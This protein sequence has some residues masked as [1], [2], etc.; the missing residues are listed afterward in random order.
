MPKKNKSKRFFLFILGSLFNFG[1]IVYASNDTDIVKSEI[2]DISLIDLKDKIN[3]SLIDLK[4]SISDCYEFKSKFMS[5][6]V[7]KSNKTVS[8][9]FYAALISAGTTLCEDCLSINK[10]LSSLI[11]KYENK[12]SSEICT[13]Y[14]ELANNSSK[15]KISILSK[16]VILQEQKYEFSDLK[17]RISYNVEYLQK[18]L[19]FAQGKIDLPPIFE[20]YSIIDYDDALSIENEYGLSYL[21]MEN[22]ANN[23]FCMRQACLNYYYNVKNGLVEFEPS[24]WKS[25]MVEG[26]SL[27]PKSIQLNEK[28]LDAY[29]KKYNSIKSNENLQ[30]L[31]NDVYKMVQHFKSNLKLLNL[32]QNY[33][34]INKDAK[35]LPD[36]IKEV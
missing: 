32:W 1:G 10:S 8:D 21:E 3:K 33:V 17:Y 15:N 5:L 9:D 2:D 30:G 36:P 19:S 20:G 25:I 7:A 11:K 24:I 6:Y 27:L 34:S 28:F 26:E 31:K 23:L 18:W 13:A 14:K 22:V 16:L 29:S 35:S 4:K 12:I